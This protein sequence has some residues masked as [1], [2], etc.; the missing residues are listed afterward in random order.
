MKYSGLN[1]KIIGC[2]QERGGGAMITNSGLIS[3]AKNTLQREGLN[4]FLGK[5]A[6]FPRNFISGCMFKRFF[7]YK[8]II[9]ARDEAKYLPRIRDYS[10]HIIE[11]HAQAEKLAGEG[12]NVYTGFK[13]AGRFLDTGAIAFCVFI[14]RDLAHIGWLA[15]NEDAKS[16]FE[17]WPYPVDFPYQG[18]TGGTETKKEYE[19]NGLMTYVYYKRFEY[20]RQKG[21]FSVKNIV[22]TSNTASNKVHSKFNPL[23]KRGFYLRIGY[24]WQFWCEMPDK[25]AKLNHRERT[26]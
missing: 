9:I 2:T 5:L 4:T 21:I 6:A 7:V 24:W 12:L 18:C 26:G 20:L 1:T 16:S 11:S 8:H 15:L 23:R 14:G 17:P 10:F 13:Q 3:L 22:E 25:T 19:G